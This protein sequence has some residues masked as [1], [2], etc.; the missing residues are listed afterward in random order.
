MSSH[1][2]QVVKACGTMNEIRRKA[3]R[4]EGLEPAWLKAIEPTLEQLN[5]RTECVQLKGNNFQSP[6]QATKQDVLEFES[7]VR[8]LIDPDIKL[9]KY[10]KN[11]LEKCKGYKVYIDKHY[12]ER[13][14]IFQVRYQYY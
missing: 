11:D 6:S 13:N 7:K 14:Y 5:S 1:L 10:T 9:G 8:Q 12:R 3:D 2:E 4:E